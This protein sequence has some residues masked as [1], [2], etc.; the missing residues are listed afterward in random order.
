MSAVMESVA[1]RSRP[2]TDGAWTAWRPA[3][4]TGFLAATSLEAALLLVSLVIRFGSSL[5]TALV[6]QRLGVLRIWG[7]WDWSWYQAIATSGYAANHTRESFPGVF[8]DATAFAPGYPSAVRAISQAIHI[9]GIDA[10][11]MISFACTVTAFIGLYRLAQ[12]GWDSRVAQTALVLCL[13]YPGALFLVAPYTEAPLLMCSVWAFLMVRQD[14]LI[15]AGLFVAAATA[16]KMPW[17]VI[18]LPGLCV[19]WLD[20]NGWRLRWRHSRLLLI[21]GP[22]VAVVA[23]WMLWQ[24]YTFGN[25]LDFLQAQGGWTPGF[26][27]FWSVIASDFM[28]SVRDA[29]SGGLAVWVLRG[30]DVAALVF[31]LAMALYVLLRVRRSYGVFL[32]TGFLII[33]DSGG[34]F[35][36]SEVRFLVPFFPLFLG[37]ALI[38]RRHPRVR[39]IVAAIW[40]PL[41]IMSTGRFVSA[42]WAG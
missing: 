28:A 14:R 30:L 7:Q 11:L 2:W 27:P 41:L 17:L 3:L 25:P 39:L 16:V 1:G 33:N 35:I 34:N 40:I 21:A 5:P 8:Q 6:T 13:I 31:F 10:G 29:S 15:I 38:T 32:L 42:L 9:P 4:S 37:L 36:S 20:A 24:W 12:L 23:V 26:T 19:E 18:L 22:A